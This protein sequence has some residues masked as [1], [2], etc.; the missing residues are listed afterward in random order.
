MI[1]LLLHIGAIDLFLE[2]LSLDNSIPFVEETGCCSSL[3]KS[4]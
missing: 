3:G 4:S 1:R 2:P